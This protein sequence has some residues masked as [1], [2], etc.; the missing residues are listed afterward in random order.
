LDYE[1]RRYCFQTKDIKNQFYFLAVGSK[2]SGISKANIAKITL[3]VPS[4][5]EQLAIASFLSDMD[6]EIAAMAAKLTKPVRSNRA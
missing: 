4:L 6:A 1:Y 5:P 3:P 2:V